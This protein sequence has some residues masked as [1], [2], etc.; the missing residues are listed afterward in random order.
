MMEQ[1]LEPFKSS[2]TEKYGDSEFVHYFDS[3]NGNQI[4]QRCNKF[5]YSLNGNEGEVSLPLSVFGLF[6]KT[7]RLLRRLLRTDKGNCV[8]LTDKCR[9]IIFYQFNVYVVNLLDASYVSTKKMNFRNP[10]YSGVLVTEDE[11]IYFGEYRGNWELSEIQIFRSTDYGDSWHPI[12]TFPGGS[13][14][15]VHSLK[16]DPYE[17]KIWTFTGDFEGQCKVCVSDPD[18]KQIEFLGDGG[19]EWRAVEAFFLEDRVVWGMDSPLSDVTVNSLDRESRL[20]SIG[21]SLD[22]PVW[23]GKRLKGGGAVIQTTVES[24]KWPGVKSSNSSLYYSEDYLT[25]TSIMS[26]EKDRYSNK[27]FR[28]GLVAFAEGPQELDNLVLN[29]EAL[30]E[31]DGLAFTFSNSVKMLQ[32]SL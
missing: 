4:Y 17:K 25:W 14:F 20:L 6:S 27:Y 29:G 10:L 24:L 19:Q 1:N 8:W 5:V 13:V 22:G 12:Y 31:I 15:H 28:H 7:S 32:G 11:S 26:W 21:Q 2:L 16:W 9:L 3:S 23:F 18:F 30:K